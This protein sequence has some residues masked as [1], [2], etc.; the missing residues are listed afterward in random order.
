MASAKLPLVSCAFDGGNIVQKGVLPLDGGAVQLRLAIEPDVYT[1]GTDKTAHAQW[2]YFKVS[3]CKGVPLRV[4]IED[5]EAVC[6]YPD[7]FKGYTTACSYDRRRWFRARNA[8]YVTGAAHAAAPH[9][10]RHDSFTE[11]DDDAATVAGDASFL[12]LARYNSDARTFAKPPLPPVPEVAVTADVDGSRGVLQWS[13]TP[14][15]DTVYFAYWTPYSLER[16]SDV[17]AELATSPLCEAWSLGQSLDGRDLDVLTFGTGPL[18]LWVAA[19]QH[20]GETMAEWAAEGCARKLADAD[21][22]KARALRAAATVHV[23]PN[24]CPDGSFRGHLRTNA[25]GANLNREWA[26]GVYGDYEAPTLARSPEVYHMLK[27]LDARGCDGYIDIHGD[28]EIEANFTAG[29]E[30]C[31]CYDAAMSA[32]YEGF[33][34]HFCKATPDFQHAPGVEGRGYEPTPPGEANL[35]VCTNAIATRYGCLAVTLEQPF[36]DSTFHTPEPV[37]GWSGPRALKLGAALVDALLDTV[38]AIAARK[39]GGAGPLQPG[40][41]PL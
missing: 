8:T 30:G 24:M 21:D 1:N 36:K 10:T 38:P 27:H 35:S 28:E 32:H 20:P 11:V 6:S 33:C 26:S 13:L 9:L 5:I 19:R 14:E 18:Q 22:P 39:K 2:F 12:P 15:F 29:A 41:A 23:V 40:V 17:V 4:A 25:S 3:R 37:C 16:H 7:G 31:P 34:Q